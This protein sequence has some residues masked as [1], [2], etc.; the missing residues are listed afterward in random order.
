[1]SAQKTKRKS[2][3]FLS[4]FAG[5]MGDLCSQGKP[6]TTENC[7]FVYLFVCTVACFVSS[8]LCLLWQEVHLELYPS[9][10]RTPE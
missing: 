1:M 4:Y 9:G 7:L 10:K 3:S 8:C 5:N 2:V 6:L